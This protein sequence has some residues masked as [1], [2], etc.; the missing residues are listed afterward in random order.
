VPVAVP[1]DYNSNGT[2]DAADYVMWRKGVAPLANE[3][4]VIGGTGVTN[5]GDYT[6]W[7]ARFGN[8]SGSGSGLEVEAVPE[9]TT[10]VLML[11]AGLA[12][13]A[14]SRRRS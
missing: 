3:V 6:A 14:S 2:V 12:T 5:S 10:A 11:V 9:P 4:D 1:G 8:I 7:R 13:V